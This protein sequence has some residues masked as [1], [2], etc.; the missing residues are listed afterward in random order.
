MRRVAKNYSDLERLVEVFE[1]FFTWRTQEEHYTAAG[2]SQNA[3]PSDLKGAFAAVQDAME[4]I[5]EVEGYLLDSEN[6][7]QAKM[8]ASIRQTY[9]TEAIIAY[10]VVLH[11]AGCM[12]SRDA[13]LT[14][15]DLATVVATETTG[16]T[17]T[18]VEAQRMKELVSSFAQAS[19]RILVLKNTGKQW[20]PKYD[21]RQG[22]DTGIWDISTR[23]S[24]QAAIAAAKS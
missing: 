22:R 10:N 1:A 9:V 16:L 12:I 19:K 13:L 11:A 2:R 4:P 14:S 8:F 23:P 20:K 21:R 3:I 17:E 24:D 18:F 7:S 6:D 5:L 15:M